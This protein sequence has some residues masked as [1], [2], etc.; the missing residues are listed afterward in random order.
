MGSGNLAVVTG[1]SSGIGWEMSK[2]LAARGYDLLL[3]ARREDRL[4]ALASE[5]SHQTGR[6]TDVLGADLTQPSE[7]RKLVSAL[8]SR[9]ETLHLL[10]N[11]AGVGMVGPTVAPPLDRIMKLIELNITAV[12]ELSYETAKI[13]IPRRAGGLI[14]VA[15][16]AS[17]QAVPYMN[18]YSAAK[19]YVL[20]F[21]EALGEELREYGIRVMALCPGYTKTEFQAVAGV[22]YDD[23]RFRSVMSAAACAR[24]GLDDFDKGKRISVTGLGN[25]L[26]VLSSWIAPR[27]IT[28]K[29]GSRLMKNRAGQPL[30]DE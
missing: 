26:L 18:V 24:A 27:S 10:V 28:L 14:N 5:V 8:E 7:R 11:N 16:T 30:N 29:I 25:K 17:F 23:T 2:Q 13:M 1:A 12:T 20:S 9:K 21:T 15:S 4:R 19:A 22:K 6:N 3:V